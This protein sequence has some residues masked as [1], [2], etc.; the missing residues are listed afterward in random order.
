M[1]EIAVMKKDVKNFKIKV[2]EIM[3]NIIDKYISIEKR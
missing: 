2:T 3:K 1:V